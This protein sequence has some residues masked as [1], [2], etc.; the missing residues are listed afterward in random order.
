MT[1]ES[2]QSSLPTYANFPDPRPAVRRPRL[3]VNSIIERTDPAQRSVQSLVYLGVEDCFATLEAEEVALKEREQDLA[4]MRADTFERIRV[5]RETE[6]LLEAR[7]KLL[8]D[9]EALLAE[10]MSGT[11][12]DKG[13]A[14]LDRSLKETRQALKQANAAVNEREEIIAQ[15]RAEMNELKAI[16]SRVAPAAAEDSPMTY[17]QVSHKS[18]SD[19]VAFLK[20]RE[21]FIEESENTLFDKAQHLQEWETRLQQQ[22]H[23]QDS[24][25]AQSGRGSQNG[26]IAFPRTASG[27]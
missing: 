21:A 3:A 5:V 24:A 26:P 9:R 19:Q 2:A 16:S 13:L 20:E 27:G 23:D 17:E 11:S 1:D 25:T 14:A 12:A 22:E 7:E 6:I 18:L 8:D 10:R 15:L 4:Q